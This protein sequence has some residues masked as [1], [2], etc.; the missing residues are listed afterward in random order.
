M[1]C[2][3]Y[4][5]AAIASGVFKGEIAS[6]SVTVKRNKELVSDDEEVGR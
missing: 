4:A 3:R 1:S 5:E 2:S 6:L